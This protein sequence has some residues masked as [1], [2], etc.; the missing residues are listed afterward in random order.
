MLIIHAGMHKTGSS[1]IQQTLHRWDGTGADYL[2]WCFSNHSGLFFLMFQDAPE[3]GGGFKLAG[4]RPEEAKRLA[5]EWGGKMSEVLEKRAADKVTHPAI[6]SAEV[7]SSASEAVVQRLADYMRKY[8]PDIRVVA[9]VRPPVSFMIS[10]FQQRMKTGHVHNFER[11]WIWPNYRDRFETLDR[12]FGRT[13]VTLKLFKREHLKDGDVVL[14]FAQEIGVDL[15]PSD[16]VRTNESM[17]LEAAALLDTFGRYAEPF[18]TGDRLSE[19]RRTRFFDRLMQ[20][21]SRRFVLDETVTDPI[22]AANRA[23]LD[24]MED[25]LG[26]PVLD[27]TPQ[28][29][30][31]IASEADLLAVALEALPELQKAI[32]DTLASQP[33]HRHVAASVSLLSEAMRLTEAKKAP[34][35]L[36]K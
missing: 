34:T 31:K 30:F 7:I 21:G 24:W 10:A 6:F 17:S 35:L 36:D 33:T 4:M 16:V 14:D 18:V 23:D 27:A 19:Q 25:R 12:V 29:D 5:D 26:M 1:S 11:L 22:L 32:A 8:E 13:N 15:R 3:D 20:I 28:S 2:P 9:Y